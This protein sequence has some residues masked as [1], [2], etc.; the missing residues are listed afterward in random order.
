MSCAANDAEAWRQV[1]AYTAKVLK[2]AK[3]ANLPVLQPTKYAADAARHRRRGDR[4][5]A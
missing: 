5:G 4:L 3:P 1:G 2:G